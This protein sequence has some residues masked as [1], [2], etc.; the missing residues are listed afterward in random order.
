MRHIS[1]NAQELLPL[2]KNPYIKQGEN[3]SLLA[4]LVNPQS[5]IRPLLYNLLQR[6]ELPAIFHFLVG[7]LLLVRSRRSP[8][9]LRTHNQSSAQQSNEICSGSNDQF[10]LMSPMNIAYKDFT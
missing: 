5:V 7:I 1:T 9:R 2:N 6:I 4:F 10:G 8:L 3:D